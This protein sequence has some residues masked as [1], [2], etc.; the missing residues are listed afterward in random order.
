MSREISVP[1]I[2]VKC[3]SSLTHVNQMSYDWFQGSYKKYSSM[4][5]NVNIGVSNL[6]PKQ[7]YYVNIGVFDMFPNKNC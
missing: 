2:I 3:L 7:K 5:S 1:K 6:F 4:D